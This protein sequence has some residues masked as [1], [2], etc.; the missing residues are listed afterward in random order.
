MLLRWN[1]K[2]NASWN[3]KSIL[4]KRHDEHG[5]GHLTIFYWGLTSTCTQVRWDMRS[6]SFSGRDRR[7]RKE[8]EASYDRF[9]CVYSGHQTSWSQCSNIQADVN[10]ERRL[11]ILPNIWLM[12]FLVTY[13]HVKS[14][15]TVIPKFRHI[16]VH[17]HILP[18]LIVHTRPLV[19]QPYHKFVF[20]FITLIFHQKT[21]LPPTPLAVPTPEHPGEEWR[22]T[23]KK[24]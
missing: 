13:T 19:Q 17:I 11:K 14:L 16:Q 3:G 21:Y 15:S 18:V 23:K 22:S 4:R 10:H 6:V 7:V 20:L 8:N 1:K 2:G 12:A 9:A 5:K 24:S